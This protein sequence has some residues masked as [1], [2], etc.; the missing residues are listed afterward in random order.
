MSLFAP[1]SGDFTPDTAKEIAELLRGKRSGAGWSAPC[2][3]HEDQTASLSIGEGR[4]GKLLLH[5]H[6]GCTFEAILAAIR[7]LGGSQP[8]AERPTATPEKLTAVAE[9]RYTHADGRPFATKTRYMDG[10]G[11]KTFRWKPMRG[12]AKAPLYRLNEIQGKEAVYLP[13]GEKDVDRLWSEGLPATC[14]PDGASKNTQQSKW[15]A[16]H[17]QQ[18]VQ[19]G[20]KRVAILA[21][22]DEAGLAHAHA[23]AR[24]CQGAGIITKLVELPGLAEHQDVSDWLDAGRTKVDLKARVRWTV[25]YLAPEPGATPEP[26]IAIVDPDEGERHLIEST[27]L[28][29]AAQIGLAHEFASLFAGRSDAP[30][31]FLYLS[32]LTAFAAAISPYVTVDAGF[33][34]ERVGLYTVL[35][36]ASH[37]GRKTVSRQWTL[38]LFEG[39]ESPWNTHLYIPE[40]VPGSDVGL[41]KAAKK[42]DGKPMLLHPDEFS[43]LTGKMNIK[44][45]TYTEML[46]KLFDAQKIGGIS[47]TFDVEA[48]VEFSL[49][50]A[51]T[52]SLWMESFTSDTM[53]VGFL[54]RLFV[55]PAY[56]AEHLQRAQTPDSAAVAEIR[57]RVARALRRVAQVPVRLDMGSEALAIFEAWSLRCQ[58]TPSDG[59]GTPKMIYHEAWARL[60]T[61]AKR[62]AAALT[63]AGWGR[64]APDMAVDPVIDPLSMTIACALADWEFQAR[65]WS[66]PIH[67]DNEY[68]VR[69]FQLRRYLRRVLPDKGQQVSRRDV[70]QHF[71]HW[72]ATA[73]NWAVAAMEKNEE[74]VVKTVGGKPHEKAIIAVAPKG[75]FP[76]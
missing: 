17:T 44:N 52:D 41:V 13:E 35:I 68:A 23:V 47:K 45:S 25:D 34:S 60:E 26:E 38:E 10:Q 16:E 48:R 49:L 73:F 51:T 67:A 43:E 1:V 69:E 3:A 42:A 4:D 64:L 63:V 75:L 62:M 9:Y 5:C 30:Y 32:F 46:N 56:R 70:Q 50:S 12:E 36:G 27:P 2:P 54:N 74:I 71:S 18:L 37:G 65:L 66:K 28:P 6:A 8:P 61:Y 29:E 57:T 22:H 40:A 31:P 15:T 55:V 39:L 76:A 72:G 20:V 21:D 58:Q 59:K 53:Q 11:K 24:A 7:A 33:K 14:N 19:A